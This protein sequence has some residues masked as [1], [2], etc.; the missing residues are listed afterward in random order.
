MTRQPWVKV[1]SS[2]H[3][4]HPLSLRMLGSRGGRGGQAG[5]ECCPAVGWGFLNSSWS[6]YMLVPMHSKYFVFVIGHLISRDCKKC[7]NDTQL[8]IF[9]IISKKVTLSPTL[10][11]KRRGKGI[12]NQKL[13]YCMSNIIANIGGNFSAK[14]NNNDLDMQFFVGFGTLSLF[15]LLRA[16][17]KKLHEN[18]YTGKFHAIYIY[19]WTKS[20]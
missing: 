19:P 6:D 18:I 2:W 17:L 20:K 10:P 15:V 13:A 16:K 5:L 9:N 1:P 11:V 7:Q 14:A 3:L 4:S 8:Y 12:N